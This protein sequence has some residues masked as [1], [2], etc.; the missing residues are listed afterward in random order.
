VVGSGLS[1]KVVMAVDVDRDLTFTN[2]DFRV[3]F[4]PGTISTLSTSNFIP[5]QFLVITGTT[6]NDT[7]T[8]TG[9]GEPI[10]G[11]A[12]D[13]TLSGGSETTACSVGSATTF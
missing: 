4:A 10:Y 13:D 1:A 11:V 12:G 2:A 6:G 8:G 9:V 7:L 3:E 5:G